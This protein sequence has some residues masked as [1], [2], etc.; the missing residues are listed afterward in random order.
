MDFKLIF[1]VEGTVALVAGGGVTA[2]RAFE[3]RPG[4]DLFAAV[5]EPQL[6]LLH[7]GDTA[8]ASA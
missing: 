5:S 3:S 6:G 4:H 7:A 1:S 2:G 8:P